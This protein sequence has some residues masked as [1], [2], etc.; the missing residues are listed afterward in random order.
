MREAAFNMA[1]IISTTGFT[2]T[3]Y[4]LWGPLAETLFFCAM[5][6]C[7]CSGSTAGGPKVFRYQLL[8]Q[9]IAGE[10]RRLHR[11]NVV[12]VPHFQGAPV[13]RRG[14]RLGRSPSS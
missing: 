3:D 2:S 1:S 9:A 7:G 11:P 14:A 5:M 12:F 6:I 10:V 13:T 8:C 4:G